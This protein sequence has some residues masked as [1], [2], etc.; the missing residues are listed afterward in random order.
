MIIS[1]RTN[2][3]TQFTLYFS[4]VN[5]CFVFRRVDVGTETDLQLLTECQNES[6]AL[7]YFNERVG[8]YCSVVGITPDDMRK[9]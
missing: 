2:G 6:E 7:D 8:F 3:T 5:N 4:R 9:G 1:V